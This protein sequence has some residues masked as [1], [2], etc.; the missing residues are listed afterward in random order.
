MHGMRPPHR[1]LLQGE[2]RQGNPRALRGTCLAQTPPR[3]PSTS[4]PEGSGDA[5]GTARA[6]ALVRSAQVRPRRLA[7]AVW[8]TEDLLLSPSAKAAP[9]EASESSVLSNE[10]VLHPKVNKNF[11]LLD[12]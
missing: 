8:G 6:S 2:E 11:K 5:G 9:D 1:S 10:A 4:N 3:T 12:I 7:H